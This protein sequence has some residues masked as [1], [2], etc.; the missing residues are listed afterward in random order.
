MILI[1]PLHTGLAPPPLTTAAVGEGLSVAASSS[2]TAAVT[3]ATAVEL[4]TGLRENSQCLEDAS[5]NLYRSIVESV[6]YIRSLFRALWNFAKSRCPVC[7]APYELESVGMEAD[8]GCVFGAAAAGHCFTRPRRP[9]AAWC[10]GSPAPAPHVIHY[11]ITNMEL[12]SLF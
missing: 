4:S 7:P 10:Q 3:T 12:S 11:I 1:C 5:P 8:G 2:T 9:A 6:Y